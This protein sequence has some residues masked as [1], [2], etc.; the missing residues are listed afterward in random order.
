MNSQELET[1]A[2]LE[3]FTY[4]L[5][6]SESKRQYPRRLKVLVNSIDSQPILF[7]SQGCL[8]TFD[9]KNQRLNQEFNFEDPNEVKKLVQYVISHTKDIQNELKYLKKIRKTYFGLFRDY[10]LKD[11]VY[12][13]KWSF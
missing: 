8:N 11:E 10:E 5:K 13:R 9:N 1:Y 2:P 6:S 3:Y 12:K 4:G 7:C